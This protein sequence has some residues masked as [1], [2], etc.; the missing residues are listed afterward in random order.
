[1]YVC[2]GAH[3]APVIKIEKRK[4]MKLEAVNNYEVNDIGMI[5]DNVKMVSARDIQIQ[6]VAVQP[7]YEP[8]PM[9]ILKLSRILLFFIVI[10]SLVYSITTKLLSL[11]AKDD[12]KEKYKKSFKRGL[13]ITLIAIVIFVI[14]IIAYQILDDWNI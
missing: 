3:W 11:K 12:K 10:G 14:S 6:P 7:Y 1:M 5:L 9:M 8:L 13:I 4:Y 2:R